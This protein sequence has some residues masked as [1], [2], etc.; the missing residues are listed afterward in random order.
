MEEGNLHNIWHHMEE[1]TDRTKCN[2]MEGVNT[3]VEVST[4]EEVNTM[5]EVNTMEWVNTM[6]EVNTMEWAN[7]M[8]EV[9]TME[10]V[11][12]MEEVNTTKEEE[13]LTE[14]D[15]GESCQIQ[16][17][18]SK[19][20]RGTPQIPDR[21]AGMD[22]S[23]EVSPRRHEV[24]LTLELGKIQV[25]TQVLILNK[26]LLDGKNLKPELGMMT[27]SGQRK[28]ITNSG[29]ET[30]GQPQQMKTTG[31]VTMARDRHMSL[32]GRTMMVLHLQMTIS[33][34]VTMVLHQHLRLHPGLQMTARMKVLSEHGRTLRML[35]LRMLTLSP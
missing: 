13:M 3:M 30:M 10:W 4:M 20:G 31:P 5:G 35:T 23:E 33:G 22:L 26:K 27:M 19:Q 32:N 7:T 24:D 28:K 2:T 17:L 6:E 29:Q 1:E 21:T 11:N 34:R 14:Q 8:E 25:E 18:L 12:T 9:N 16:L 15:Q